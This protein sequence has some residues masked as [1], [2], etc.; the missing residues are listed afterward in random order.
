MAVGACR[1]ARVTAASTG[2]RWQWAGEQRA[3]PPGCRLAMLVG[4]CARVPL[5]HTYEYARRLAPRLVPTGRGPEVAEV[6][7]EHCPNGHRRRGGL[8]RVRHSPG[9][10]GN[11]GTAPISADSAASSGTTRRAGIGQAG[12]GASTAADCE[13]SARDWRRR[14]ECEDDRTA[15]MRH[16][17]AVRAGDRTGAP[18][19]AHTSESRS[20]RDVPAANLVLKAAALRAKLQGLEPRLRDGSDDRIN[21]LEVKMIAAARRNTAPDSKPSST[22]TRRPSPSSEARASDQESDRRDA[23]ASLTRPIRTPTQS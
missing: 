12:R 23:N 21:E 22:T 20:T 10:C 6:P 2:A 9:I 8:I 7:P 19:G 16:R 5:A 3:G 4:G 14:P 15:R 17:C 18:R 11:G 13:S 1:R